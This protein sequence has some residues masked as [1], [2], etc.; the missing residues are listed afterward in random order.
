MCFGRPSGA[1]RCAAASLQPCELRSIISAQSDASIGRV[2]PA[3]GTFP[4]RVT[5]E[6]IVRTQ[7]RDTVGIIVKLDAAYLD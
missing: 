2:P 4:V 7:K 3:V 6:R 1:D 5:I